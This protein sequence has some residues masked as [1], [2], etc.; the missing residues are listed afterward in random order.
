MGGFGD[1]YKRDK[2][3]K[4]KGQTFKKIGY[5]PTFTQPQIIGKGKGVG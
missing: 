4:K 2:K 5:A 1:F 3:K